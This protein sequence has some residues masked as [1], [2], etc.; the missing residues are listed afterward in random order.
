MQWRNNFQEGCAVPHSIDAWR[1]AR[2]TLPLSYDHV[3]ENRAVIGSPEQC[4]AKILELE[5][6]GIEYFG[7]NC[8]LGGISHEKVRRSMD[9]FSK[10][11]MPN[12]L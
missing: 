2:T 7:C 4:V 6:Q 9:L 10:E 12:I 5:A 8:D 11:V 1:R 3:F